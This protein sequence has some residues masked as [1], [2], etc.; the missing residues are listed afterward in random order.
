LK[1]LSH[2]LSHGISALEEPVPAQRIQ[3]NITLP[4]FPYGW[5]EKNQWNRTTISDPT[6]T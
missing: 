1:R 2:V 4:F 5:D 3:A 6:I